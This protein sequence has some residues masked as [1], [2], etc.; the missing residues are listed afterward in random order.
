MLSLH[1]PNN[2]P[3]ERAGFYELTDDG[4]SISVKKK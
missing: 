4:T 3:D 2:D 1:K